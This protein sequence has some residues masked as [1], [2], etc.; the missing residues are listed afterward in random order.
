MS[1]SLAQFFGSDPLSTVLSA[2]LFFV[3]YVMLGLAP[4]CAVLYLVYFLLTLPLRRNER[5]RVFVDLL[6]V[7]LKQ[8][9]TPEA[10]ILGL[11]PAA[12]RPWGRAS[13]S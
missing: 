12:T 9:R 10:A 4:I 3:L 6:E 13:T 1:E 2:A 5:A 7:G 11:P 8:G